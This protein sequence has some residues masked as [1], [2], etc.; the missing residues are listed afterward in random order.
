MTMVQ[1]E[2]PYYRWLV[3]FL[4]MLVMLAKY[5]LYIGFALKPYM[6]LSIAYMVFS[7]GAFRFY[8]LQMFEVAM[9][10][11]YLVYV[12]SGMFALY[13]AASVRILIGIFIYIASYFIMKSILGHTKEKVIL[14][15]LAY[16]GILFNVTSLILYF[17]GLQAIGFVM[18]PDV[19][20][21]E[22]GMMLDGGYPRLIGL[23]QDPNFFVFYNTIF[24]AYYL[25]NSKGKL[26]KI[27][28]LLTI[29]TNL[30][31]FSRGGLIVMVLLLFLYMSLNHP[32]KQLKMMIGLVLSLLVAAY[33]SIVYFRF[34]LYGVFRE[35]IE[36]FSQDGGSGRIELWGRAW[37]F[38]SENPAFGIG[39]YNFADYNWH[40]YSDRLTVH[41][42]FLDI[43]SE[44][45]LIGIFFFLL[46]IGLVFYQLIR[47][48]VYKHRP[49]LFL[50]F[51]G[52]IVQ[53]GFL[54]VI[55]NDMF[56]LYIAILSAY[57]LE[58]ETAVI[59]EKSPQVRLDRRGE[60]L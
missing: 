31:T 22:Y 41:N 50:T 18:I 29:T 21:Y 34:D 59:R 20:I 55:I 17:L 36:A 37:E 56:F 49:Y 2:R 42:T 38:F 26:N 10:L 13:P 52:L 47:Q 54:T 14:K 11:F 53:M 33:V 40:Q 44:S 8:R 5:N 1:E 46:F 9:L 24:F 28:L 16:T 57:M 51:I 27:G 7:L 25:T 39:A 4:I 23:M 60:A 12:S 32:I 48:K 19:L 6:L 15:S 58:H 35:R 45:G 3:F 30:L 43:L